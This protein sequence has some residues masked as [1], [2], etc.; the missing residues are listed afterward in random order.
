MG[1]PTHNWVRPPVTGNIEASL[2]SEDEF[3][4][5]PDYEP[6]WPQ[7]HRS[8]SGSALGSGMLQRDK[9][10][11][12][13]YKQVITV[14]ANSY[15]K[16]FD[17]R[18]SGMY[19]NVIQN[20]SQL[21][22][23]V[24]EYAK[25]NI[26]PQM[27][28]TS[29]DYTKCIKPSP[30]AVHVMSNS[31]EIPILRNVGSKKTSETERTSP[32]EKGPHSK[33]SVKQMQDNFESNTQDTQAVSDKLPS[34]RDKGKSPAPAQSSPCRAPGESSPIGRIP[35]APAAPPA[36]PAAP[37]APTPT[38][39]PGKEGKGK[40]KQIHWN[41]TPKPMVSIVAVIVHK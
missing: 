29:G 27:S 21:V 15:P 32:R 19:N 28:R 6:Q 17:N 8:N 13:I 4:P 20:E 31:N 18:E 16:K 24:G 2:S 41:R 36:P 38:H 26:D 1:E 39:L 11:S 5:E 30:G 35:K 33:L 23:E 10:S 34:P 22:R 12:G 14:D 37:P 40:L 9:Q 3:I 25:S 7:M